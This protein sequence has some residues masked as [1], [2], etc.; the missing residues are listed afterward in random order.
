MDKGEPLI[1]WGKELFL[2]QKYLYSEILNIEC[3]CTE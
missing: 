2:N 3:V 1:L